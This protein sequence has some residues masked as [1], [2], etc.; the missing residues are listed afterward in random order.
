MS[1]HFTYD[2]PESV[3]S[4]KAQGGI[5][6]APEVGGLVDDVSPP[7][8]TGEVEPDV[9]PTDGEDV[10]ASPAAGE[11]VPATN[12]GTAVVI[13]PCT[14][15]DVAAPLDDAT[16]GTLVVTA[17]MGVGGLVSDIVGLIIGASVE[18][19]TTRLVVGVLLS[20]FSDGAVEA[21]AFERVGGL[22]MDPVSATVGLV[23]G[24]MLSTPKPGDV[25]M[26]VTSIGA[27]LPAVE[28]VGGLVADSVSATVE[29]VVGALVSG[30]DTGAEVSGAGGL[31][32]VNGGAV[33]PG[34][35]IVSGG[36][37]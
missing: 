32:F 37:F 33:S 1:K 20:T 10:I 9:S 25:G 29:L 22:V 28:S 19:S 23:V 26:G 11:A 18:S 6:V 16:V 5:F 13:S 24:S 34:Q 15:E 12:D 2:P 3:L 27:L 36:I 7:S 31:V 17:T 4:G 30:D 35:K 21:S 8:A 14:G